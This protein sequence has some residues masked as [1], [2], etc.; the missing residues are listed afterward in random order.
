MPYTFQ[1]RVAAVE[2][3][4]RF[5]DKATLVLKESEETTDALR[6]NVRRRSGWVGGGAAGGGAVV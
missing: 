3:A 4:T 1:D 6:T 2:A 5:Q